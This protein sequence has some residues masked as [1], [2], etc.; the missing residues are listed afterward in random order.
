MDEVEEEETAG[1]ETLSGIASA[2]PSG[3]ETF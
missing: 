3:I 1:F 2:V